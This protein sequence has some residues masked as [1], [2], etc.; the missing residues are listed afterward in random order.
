MDAS[1]RVKRMVDFH[2]HRTNIA[3]LIELGVLD[4][5]SFDGRQHLNQ[6]TQ[7]LQSSITLQ[8]QPQYNYQR[9]QPNPQTQ[10]QP[11]SKPPVATA[12]DA[13]HDISF[14]NQSLFSAGC[15]V[16]QVSQHLVLLTVNLTVLC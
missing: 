10:P 8:Q 14:V 13:P 16:A 1:S 6:Q 7:H 4:D 5:N 15:K 9:S 3:G 2:I 11:Q 12:P